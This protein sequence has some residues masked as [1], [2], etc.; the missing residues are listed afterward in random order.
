[1]AVNT[2]K[3]G[4]LLD[5]RKHATEG[6]P[7]EI[8]PIPWEVVIP[9]NQHF[10]APNQ[11]LVKVG[12]KVKRGQKIAD[13]AAPGP[14]TVPVHASITGTVKKI[15]P[16]TQSNNSEGPCIVIEADESEGAQSLDTYEKLPPLDAFTCTKEE[17]LARI[18]E[19]GITGMGGAGFPA[20]VKLNPPPNKKIDYIIANVAECEPYLTIDEAAMRE[21]TDSVIMGLGIV[22]KITGVKTA[23]IGMEDNKAD[24][25]PS[26]DAAIKKAG[27][28][29]EIR[30]E[31]CK[32]RYPQGGEK[33]LINALTGREVPSGGLPMDAGCIVSNLGTLVAIAEAFSLGK[34]LIDRSLTISGKA[35]TKPKNITAPI[36]AMISDLPPEFIGID[37]P[38]LRKV[39]FGGPMMGF[40]V[41]NVT[42]PI[43]KNTSGIV[44]MTEEETI[45]D[46]EGPCINCGRCMKTCSCSLAP[47]LMNRNLMAGDLDGALATGLLD[48]IECGSCTYN[49]PA[50][51][52]LVQRFRVGKGLLRAK[53]QA[54]QAAAAAKAQAQA[55]AAK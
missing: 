51:I 3:R 1:M 12:D 54:A 6:K 44:F 5:P 16:R 7:I 32:T 37:Y 43:Q 38:R 40:A 24:L 15:E 55:T 31:L 19:A 50:R 30:V 11:A 10:G 4:L 29:G 25:I 34:P 49:C 21:K 13:A 9:V 45:Q 35:C 18:R 23:L 17:A 39:L 22:M 8:A 36:G 26:I 47:V 28:P 20:H 53:Q 42:I 2:F 14:M 46:A 52:K 48:C 33:L 27:Y 41:P